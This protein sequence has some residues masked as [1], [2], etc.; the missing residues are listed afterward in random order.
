VIA[1]AVGGDCPRGRAVIA[2]A[3]GEEPESSAQF[4]IMGS[5]SF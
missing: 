5:L 3:A 4:V 2:R 1:R